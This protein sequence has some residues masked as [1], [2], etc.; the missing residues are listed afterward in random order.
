MN[1]TDKTKNA[2]LGLV[3]SQA[4]DYLE[5]DPETNIPKLMDMVDKLM[6]TGW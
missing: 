1:I 2:A 5:K 4:M 3:F 6:P